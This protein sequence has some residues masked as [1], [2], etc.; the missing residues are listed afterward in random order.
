MLKPA[1]NRLLLAY[2]L[3]LPYHSGKWRIVERLYRALG[4]DGW[5]AGRE[6][7]VERGGVKWRINPVSLVQR[8]LYY[9]GFYERHE[10]NWV[11]AQAKPGWTVFDVGANFGYYSLRI[12]GSLG[13][14]AVIHSFEPEEGMFRRLGEQVSL[15]G[16]TSITPRRIAL[17]NVDGEL[18]LV[19]PGKG[20]EGVGQLR[21]A[22]GKAPPDRLQRVVSMRMDTYVRLHQVERLDFV[23][24]DVEGA[25]CL[26]LEGA[27]DTLRRLRPVLMVEIN[28]EALGAFGVSA[29]WLLERIRSL[30]YDVFRIGASGLE[31]LPNASAIGDYVNAICKPRPS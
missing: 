20:N 24:I 8:S 17:S 19:A 31:P 25:E 27:Q 18:E 15:N 5:L 13:D 7:T 28:P 6:E 9:L 23:K 29:D 22:E 10:T 26:V 16:F 30:G 12:A 4:L 21:T 1:L 2:G 11:L 3:R 14:R